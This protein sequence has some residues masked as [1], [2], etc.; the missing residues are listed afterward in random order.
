MIISIFMYLV[1]FRKY[2][3]ISFDDRIM[4][5]ESLYHGMIMFSENLSESE[6]I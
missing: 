6:S 2:F 4:T 1:I 5:S 3:M